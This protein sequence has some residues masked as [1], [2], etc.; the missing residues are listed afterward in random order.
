ML[1]E[2]SAIPL[3]YQLEK[4][5]ED[6]I[7]TGVFKPGEKI[8]SESALCSQYGISRTTVRQ[9]IS[10]LVNIG[11]L[12]RA[13][14]KGTFV[15][16]L[17]VIKPLYKLS[18]F[19]E[20]MHTQGLIPHS[21]VL[22][23]SP[24]IPPIHITRALKIKEREAVILVQRLRYAGD[25]LMALADCYYPFHRFSE[26]LEEDLANNSLYHLLINKYDTI[27]SISIFNIKAMKCPREVAD[28][29][30]ITPSD[31]ILYLYETVHDQNDRV[32][33]YSEEY[34]RSDRNS[35]HM[36][37]RKQKDEFFHRIPTGTN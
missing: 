13:Q 27:P 37:I 4:I 11:K 18:G 28:L 8:P 7:S 22:K 24:M 21:K 16:D 36:E 35:F 15:A 1:D 12:V 30:Q 14:G 10:E 34:Y 9:A 19:T 32:F 20:D 17:R 6:Q 23:L 33:E 2:H 25:D 5:I 29:L 26:L 3:Y 31:P